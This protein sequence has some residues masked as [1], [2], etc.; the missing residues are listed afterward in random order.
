MQHLQSL[1][2]APSL[3]LLRSIFV[4]IDG[5]GDEVR[6][7]PPSGLGVVRRATTSSRVEGLQQTTGHMVWRLAVPT[8]VQGCG[9]LDPR[10]CVISIS[11]SSEAVSLRTR[12]HRVGM[13]RLLVSCKARE[14]PGRCYSIP[15]LWSVRTWWSSE[16]L[17]CCGWCQSPSNS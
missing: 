8:L 12:W 1:S 6:R 16:G 11:S 2:L 7:F 15:G 10:S 9:S 17:G 5:S 3:L 13:R 4:G 14:S